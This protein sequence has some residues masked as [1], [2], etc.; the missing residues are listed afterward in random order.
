MIAGLLVG[1]AFILSGC[2]IFS[3]PQNTFAPEGEVAKD[4]RFAFMLTMWF[5]LAIMIGVFGACVLIILR[6]RQRPGHDQLPKQTHGNNVLEIGW[7]IAPAALLLAFVPLVVTGIVKLGD[8]PDG[9]LPV[10]VNAYRFGW[11][12]GYQAP[13]GTVVEGPVSSASVPGELYIPIGQDVALKLHSEDVIHSF[14]VPKLAG[15]TDVMPGR[16][17]H[18]WM[19]GDKEGVYAG[20]CA[21]FCGL[22][23]ALMRFNVHVVS[24]ETYDRYVGCLVTPDGAGC[25]EFAPQAAAA[26]E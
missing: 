16:K 4:Q 19:K 25:D 8:T 23:H 21:E 14:W 9:A 7:T 2:E 22:N 18:M 26:G 11:W 5:A 20:Q 15:K 12:F 1:L 10:E 17:N 3:S 13:D 6:F 24:R